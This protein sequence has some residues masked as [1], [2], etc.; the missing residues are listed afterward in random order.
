M[1]SVK[2]KIKVKARVGAGGAKGKVALLVGT[3]KGAFMLHGDGGR[4]AWRIAGPHMLGSTVHHLVLDPRDGRT[5]LMAA[6]T[7]HLGPTVFRST[8]KGKTWKEA[9]KPPAFKKASGGKPATEPCPGCGAQPKDG[10]IDH[11]Y[12][13]CKFAGNVVKHTFWLTPGHASEPGVW[14]A[15]TSPQGIFRTEDGGATWEGVA[16]F[17]DD[18]GWDKWTGGQQDG[19]PEG[20][21]MHS[22]LIDPRDKRHMYIGMSSGGV[23][24]TR[25]QG[26]TWS[27]LVKG[28]RHAFIEDEKAAETAQ[29]HDP[30]RLVIHPAQPDRLYMQAHTGIYKIDRPSDRWERIGLKMPKSIGD[31]GFPIVAHPRDPDTAW[32]FPMDGTAVWP[33]TSPGGKPA[34]YV[35]RDAGKSWQRQDSGLPKKDAHLTVL[36]QAMACDGMDPLGLYFGT[37]TGD[38]WASA[39]EGKSWTRIAEHLPHIYAIEAAALG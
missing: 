33:R 34:V 16:G 10:Q 38:I 3:K 9:A 39:N 29:G 23:H 11:V 25:D 20:P 6:V 30:H 5:M 21:K 2:A 37:T 32:V 26:K 31:I 7:G 35:T 17:N 4:G 1:A 24:E 36:R 22:I 27:P 18:P 19:T 15:G 28:L 12:W 8:D 14:Y 13:W